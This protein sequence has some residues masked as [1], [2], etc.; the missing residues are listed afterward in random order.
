MRQNR[1]AQMETK[2]EKMMNE[3]EEVIS[4]YLMEMKEE[5]EEFIEKIKRV[6]H[7]KTEINYQA[8]ETSVAGRT[9][10]ENIQTSNPQGEKV[11]NSVRRASSGYA[12]KAYQT[13]KKPIQATQEADEPIFL[14]SYH[15]EHEKRMDHPDEPTNAE[16]HS[17]KRAPVES[18]YVESLLNQALLLKQ[19]GYTEEEI[20]KKLNKGKTEI[21]LL[22]KFRQN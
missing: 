18:L 14:P 13:S 1:L 8:P 6:Q 15:N 2:Q 22:L 21:E 16:V 20:A 19:Q 10:K 7:T 5:N 11:T 17:F 3:M 12:A 9:S 4:T